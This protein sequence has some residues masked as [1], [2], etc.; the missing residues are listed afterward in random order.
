MGETLIVLHEA[1]NGNW[2]VSRRG[3]RIKRE[4]MNLKHNFLA[5][6]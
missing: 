4:D 1:S 2:Y 6:H 3:P 5:L